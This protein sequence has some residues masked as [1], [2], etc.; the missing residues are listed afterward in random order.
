MKPVPLDI[1]VGIPKISVF[2]ISRYADVPQ[3]IRASD[4]DTR[5]DTQPPFDPF[6]G[7]FRRF[8]IS[9][10]QVIGAKLP[11][12]FRD[13]RHIGRVHVHHSGR[14]SIHIFSLERALGRQ[15]P[16]CHRPVKAP[17]RR[18]RRP[19]AAIICPPGSRSTGAS[20]P[21]PGKSVN[22]GMPSLPLRRS[23]SGSR[24]YAPGSESCQI[25]NRFPCTAGCRRPL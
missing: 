25:W 13:I 22:S 20:P 10:L 9:G 2:N 15:C 23:S 4:G 24:P 16:A 14:S 5:A 8:K 12:R 3:S 21:L 11:H 7:L 18:P 6:K 1:A 17:P 19:L